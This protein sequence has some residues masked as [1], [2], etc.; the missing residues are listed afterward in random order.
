[1]IQYKKE[2]FVVACT[3]SRAVMHIL[4]EAQHSHSG[5]CSHVHISSASLNQCE[6][7]MTIPSKVSI[8][9]QN[10]DTQAIN[11]PPQSPRDSEAVCCVKDLQLHSKVRILLKP[12]TGGTVRNHYFGLNLKLAGFGIP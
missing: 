3:Q 12:E 8:I 1:M 7:E 6:E 2:A 5:T 4:Q 11:L 9:P 10:R